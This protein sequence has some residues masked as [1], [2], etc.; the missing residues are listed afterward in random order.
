MLN[1]FRTEFSGR[2]LASWK[3]PSSCCC[4]DSYHA[5]PV[6]SETLKQTERERAGQSAIDV[7]VGFKMSHDPLFFKFTWSRA[8]LHATFLW[9]R[10]RLRRFLPPA[11]FCD[12]CSTRSDLLISLKHAMVISTA[13]R[14][15]LCTIRSTVSRRSAFPSLDTGILKVFFRYHLKPSKSSSP[16]WSSVFKSRTWGWAIC[17]AL[18]RV[19]VHL[20]HLHDFQN[21]NK[22]F[23]PCHWVYNHSKK[24]L[25][26]VSFVYFKLIQLKVIIWKTLI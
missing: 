20:L 1:Y 11:L 24:E 6:I 26:Y 7:I 16:K 13:C 4:D 14:G 23:T 17:A 9:T 10:G 5:N 19:K 3:R 2:P 15:K 22:H 21:W 18:G 25:K 12:K 8:S